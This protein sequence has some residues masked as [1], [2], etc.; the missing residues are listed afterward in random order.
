MSRRNDGV[1]YDERTGLKTPG[2]KL[3]RDYYTKA[4][5]TDADAAHPQDY[6]QVPGPD[7]LNQRYGPAEQHAISTTTFLDDCFDTSSMTY[8]PFPRLSLN[9]SFVLIASNA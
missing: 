1:A 4:W 9:P 7:G 8:V 2:R 6:V 5:S 3:R